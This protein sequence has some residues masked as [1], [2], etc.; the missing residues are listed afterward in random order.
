MALF[1][2]NKFIDIG[3]T[4]DGVTYSVN[5]FHGLCRPYGTLHNQEP[6]VTDPEILRRVG[7]KVYKMI[8]DPWVTKEEYIDNMI[9]NNMS[10][11]QSSG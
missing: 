9:V 3:V 7:A 4:V 8:K 1:D 10:A 5:Y 6:L 11:S 2:P